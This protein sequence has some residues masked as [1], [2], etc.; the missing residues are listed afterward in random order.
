MESTWKEE[1]Q[2]PGP[3]AIEVFFDGDC[4]LCKRE[5]A[6][7]ERRDKQQRIVATDITSPSFDAAQFDRSQVEFM[8]TIQGRLAD[9]QWITGVEVFRQL[10]AAVGF[11]RLVRMSRLRPVNWALNHA[12]GIF[13]KHRLRLTGRCETSACAIPSSA[14]G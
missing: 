9:G 7:L 6:F 10:Y 3:E 4:P 11:T 8:A 5:I 14:Q 1:H 2:S 13:A 12:Y